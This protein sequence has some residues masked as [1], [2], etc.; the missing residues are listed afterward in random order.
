M[1]V[2]Y[3]L[4]AVITGALTHRLRR[5]QRALQ[6]RERRTD[7]LYRLVTSISTGQR[8]H[9]LR[10]VAGLLGTALKRP[11]SVFLADGAGHLRPQGHGPDAF[12]LNDKETAVAVWSLQSAK[13]AGWG[14]SNLPTTDAHF[15]P[16][17]GRHSIVGVLALR[18]GSGPGL[19]LE[20]EVLLKAASQQLGL[21]LEHEG[22][23]QASREAERLR[24]SEQL[25]QALLNSVSHELRTPLT[26]LLGT[27]TASDPAQRGPLLKDLASAGG[28]LNRVIENLPDMARLNSGVLAPQMDWHDPAELVRLTVQRLAEPLSGH[29]I[30]LDLLDELPLLKADYRF[31]EHALSNLLLN[32]AAYA[33]AVGPSSF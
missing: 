16:L 27:A 9:T 11:V 29:P 28:R 6:E 15:V 5:N 10:E 7:L 13:P 12:A 21:S 8:D 31:M 17:Q 19:S 30:R 2:A 20:D 33:P 1:I 23:Q 3:F 32:A 4:A 18:G 26:A 22:L 24:E 25:H 14:T